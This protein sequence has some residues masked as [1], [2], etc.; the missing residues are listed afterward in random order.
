M[1]H[2]P[3]RLATLLLA[4]LSITPGLALAGN[5]VTFEFGGHLDSVD[6][7]LAG[8]FE[9]GDPFSGSLT[10]DL[11]APDQLPDNEEYGIYHNVVAFSCTINGTHSATATGG[12]CNFP[13]GLLLDFLVDEGFTGDAAAG[14]LPQFVNIP[15]TE[16]SGDPLFDTDEMPGAPFPSMLDFDNAR[17]RI[18]FG[19]TWNE[20]EVAGRI[21]L[22]GPPTPVAE[23]SWGQVK[24][25]FGR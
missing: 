9:V 6:E 8:V 3:Y 22:D 2:V 14:M 5:T 7:S 16:R 21:T 13:V 20:N 19:P 12:R 18:R 15:L 25:I 10:Y 24:A 23:T 1:K 11:D 17:F 4:T